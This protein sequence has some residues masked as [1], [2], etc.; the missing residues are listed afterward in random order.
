MFL[1]IRQALIL[2][3]LPER[4]PARIRRQVSPFRARCVQALSAATAAAR[5]RRHGQHDG[6]RR[7]QCYTNL[8]SVISRYV[9][10]LH[11]S[12]VCASSVD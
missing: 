2:N 9:D 6:G 12:E 11:C 8:H 4:I 10:Y 5:T 7:E 1:P 3:H